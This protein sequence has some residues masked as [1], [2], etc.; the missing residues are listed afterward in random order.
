[1]D[2]PAHWNPYY[3]TIDEFPPTYTIRPLVVIDIYEKVAQNPGY[4]CSVVDIKTW[5]KS[6]KGFQREPL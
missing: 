3:P 1:L 2:P 4:H 5:E 6:M